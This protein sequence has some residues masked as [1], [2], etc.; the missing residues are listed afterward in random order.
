MA[1]IPSYNLETENYREKHNLLT[2]NLSLD[3]WL[4][5]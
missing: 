3:V 1:L 5:D 2:L 4:K